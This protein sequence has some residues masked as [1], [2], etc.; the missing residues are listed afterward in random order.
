MAVPAFRSWR[1][2]MN[3]GLSSKTVSLIEMSV[4]AR[5]NIVPRLVGV[6]GVANVSV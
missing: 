4:Q 3:I 5:W 6:P 2:A 1:G